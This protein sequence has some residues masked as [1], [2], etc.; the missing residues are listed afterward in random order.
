MDVADFKTVLPYVFIMLKGAGIT[1]AISAL[2]L[3]FAAI[4]GTTVGIFAAGGVRFAYSLT[5]LYVELIRSVPLLVLIF[6]AYYAIPVISSVNITPYGAATGA[7]S[8]YGGAYMAE[9][10]R[11][12]I[13][14]ISKHQWEAARAL[15]LRYGP[16]MALIVF[17]QALRVT[18][19]AGIGIF[20]DLIKGSSVASIIGFVELMQTAVNVRNTIYNLSPILLAGFLYFCICFGLSRLGAQLEHRLEQRW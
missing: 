10:V 5:R 3:I 11:S 13:Q 18:V 16:I 1:V 14:S 6:F 4:I 8:I 20:I 2:A 19:P 9:V 17:P 15:G 7:L 12:G